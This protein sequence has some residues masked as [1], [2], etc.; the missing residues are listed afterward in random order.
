[1]NTRTWARA[2]AKVIAE[3]SEPVLEHGCYILGREV[4]LLEDRLAAYLG[5]RHAVGCNSGFGAHLLSLLTLGIGVGS[6]VLVSPFSPPSFAGAVVRRNAN[7]YFADVDEDDFHIS[8]SA[9]R[10]HIADVEL[11]VVHH[12]FGGTADMPAIC[13]VVDDVL[14]IEVLTYSFGAEIE[15]GRRA[16]TYGTVATCCL[17]EETT[18]GAYGDAGMVWT[19]DTEL[20]G[21]LREIRKEDEYHEVY[22]GIVA[23]NF[24]MDT[25]HA[26]ILLRKLDR[27][28]EDAR[29]R[30]EQVRLL[31]S[32]VSDVDGL[33]VPGTEQDTATRFVILAEDRERLTQYLRGYGVRAEPWWPVPLHL[34]PGFAELGYAKGDFPNAE[35][36]AARSLY[37]RLPDTKTQFARVPEL[38]SNFTF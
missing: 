36:V 16:G 25:L 29:L 14:I 13:A 35:S 9:L 12:L 2:E 23:G 11:L 27:W 8:A 4:A 3:A 6:N 22:S 38:L 20:A 15:P 18:L 19:D 31:R 32:A 37:L 17:R 26:A 28:A 24:H 33:V 5:T 21:K 1:M 7:L 30:R 34:Q 10:G